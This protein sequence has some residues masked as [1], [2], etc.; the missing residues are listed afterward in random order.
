MSLCSENKGAD[1]QR[2][3][4]ATFVFALCR[5]S[6]DAAHLISSFTIAEIF[7]VIF[8]FINMK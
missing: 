6:H 8:L 2:G 4:H 7:L 5:F 1:Q 3:Y